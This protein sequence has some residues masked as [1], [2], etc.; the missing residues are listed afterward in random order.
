[1]P[2]SL[3]ENYFYN[4]EC[5]QAYLANLIDIFQYYVRKLR[6]FLYLSKN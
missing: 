6:D 4:F 1:M 3:N 5:Y 2:I